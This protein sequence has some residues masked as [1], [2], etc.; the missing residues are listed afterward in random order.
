MNG[1][2]RGFVVLLDQGGPADP[3]GPPGP[4]GTRQAGDPAIPVWAWHL[5]AA[6]YDG[7]D[8]PAA[9]SW[10]LR[11]HAVLELL[12]GP[13]DFR[14]VH[15]WHAD[16]VLPMLAEASTRRGGSSRPYEA[17]ARLHAAAAAGERH[18]RA[19]WEAALE[20][21]LREVYRHAYATAEAGE[22]AY[23]N[24]RAYAVANG[25]DEAEAD[26]YGRRYADLSTDAG[27][28][29]FSDANAVANARA[30]A[31][32]YTTADD[33]ARAWAFWGARVHA[34]ARAG[35]VGSAD[36]GTDPAA[37]RSAAYGRLAEGLL[38]AL[39]K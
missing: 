29:A 10:A 15:A 19:T 13:V 7:Q 23:A 14:V 35:A 5:L 22:T 24:A 11:A 2:A 17:P 36:G 30:T 25:Y 28:R 33:R 8:E 31:A 6:L 12:D 4:P 21:A 20:P 1:H 39:S 3:P 34:Y 18:D 27:V 16:V 9:E 26:R 37:E 38:D 32:A